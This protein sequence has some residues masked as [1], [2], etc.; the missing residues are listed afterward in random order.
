MRVGAH[1]TVS[2]GASRLCITCENDFH[3]LAVKKENKRFSPELKSAHG[4]C[5]TLLAWKL[6]RIGK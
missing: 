4:L 2:Q 5:K 6:V 3:V 1:F